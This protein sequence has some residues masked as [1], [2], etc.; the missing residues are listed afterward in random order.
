MSK[1]KFVHISDLLELEESSGV[2][3]RANFDCGQVS[4]NDF[5]RKFA[6]QNSEKHVGQTHV[7][8]EESPLKVIG[9]FTLS[10]F[11][12]KKESLLSFIKFPSNEIPAILIGRLA[13]DL[14]EQKKAMV[15]PY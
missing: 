14:S 3:A 6:K 15:K 7:L 10:S 1:Q 5:I 4:L 12:V 11:S 2:K 13:T 9:Y 8:I